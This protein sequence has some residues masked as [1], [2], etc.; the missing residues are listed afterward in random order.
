MLLRDKLK[1]R[2]ASL[3]ARALPL[4]FVLVFAGP[5]VA[6][7]PAEL[8]IGRANHAFDHLG[9]IGGQADA[10][11]AC[12]ATI[13]YTGGLGEPGYH[14]LPAKKEFDALCEK[15]RAYNKHAESIGIEL[16]IGYLCA[17]SIVKLEIFDNN[18]TPEFRA[19]FKTRPSEWLQQDRHGKALPSWYGGDYVPA[20][21][22]NPD[23]RA[24]E[25]AMVR[26]TLETGH[27][28]VFFDNPTVHPDG[29][30]CRYCIQKFV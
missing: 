21:M 29:C 10:A 1:K 28:G 12:G 15:V 11:A 13:I 30:Y 6:Q 27:A 7:I 24:Y 18:W 3:H 17:T 22:N 2:T 9:N 8:R 19:Q 26:Y 25:R 4:V 5:A 20:C 16:P 14:G 23:W